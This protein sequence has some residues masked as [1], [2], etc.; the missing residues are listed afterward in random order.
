MQNRYCAPAILAFAPFALLGGQS[1][2]PAAGRADVPVKSVVLNEQ[3]STIEK[4]GRERDAL[5]KKRDAQR[6]EMEEDLGNLSVG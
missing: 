3:E 6:R 1:T 2:Q 5:I 4:L